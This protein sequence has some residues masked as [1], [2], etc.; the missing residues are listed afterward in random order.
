TASRVSGD[1]NLGF[2]NFSIQSGGACPLV[3]NLRATDLTSNTPVIS[4]DALPTAPTGGYDYYYSPIS[5][6]PDAIGEPSGNTTNNSLTL[7][8]LSSGKRYYFYV[9]ANCG[10]DNYGAWSDVLSFDLPLAH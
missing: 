5:V 9:R 7:P 6:T 8:S 2:D 1:Y 4:W 10:A 3:Q